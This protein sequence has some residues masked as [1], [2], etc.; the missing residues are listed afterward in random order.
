MHP[1][2]FNVPDVA[3]HGADCRALPGPTF[4]DTARSLLTHRKG[5]R[6][7]VAEVESCKECRGETLKFST[8]FWHSM[9]NEARKS[10]QDKSLTN[11]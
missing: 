7:Q 8:I 3:L 9:K 4:Q 11:G 2:R 10:K 1:V 5:E 6:P